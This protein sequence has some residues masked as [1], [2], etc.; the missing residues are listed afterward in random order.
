MG[1]S[2][3]WTA[4]ESE[5]LLKTS[6]FQLRREKC[7]LPDQRVM[8]GYYILDFPDWVHVI[9]MT[10]DHQ[11]I[12]LRQY[13]HAAGDIFYEI[14][15][16]TTEPGT[17]EEPKEAAARELLEETGYES[18]HWIGLGAYHPNPALQSNRLHVYLAQ[19]CKKVSEQNLDPFE[20]IEVV[21]MGWEEAY[22]IVMSQDLQHGL[23]LG[24]LALAQFYL[25]GS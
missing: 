15:G 14:P 3:K 5:E 20:G 2:M 6:F 4:L 13:R 24:S 17:N 19:D 16:G 8:P 1:F 7:E 12:L 23:M 9:P 10:S 21:T 22:R 25:S 18:K 11:L